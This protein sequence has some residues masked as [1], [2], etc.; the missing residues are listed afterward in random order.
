MKFENALLFFQHLIG[1]DEAKMR[2]NLSQLCPKEAPIFAETL[3]LI[4]A[5]YANQQRSG[6]TQ[7]VGAQADLLCDDNHAKSLE[8]KQVGPYLLKQKLGEG[9]MGAVYL[10]QRNDGLIEQKVA[11]KFV[12]A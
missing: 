9:G 7:L 3:A 1:L 12:F 8:G 2:E 5:H 10:G 11:V 6:F 4:D